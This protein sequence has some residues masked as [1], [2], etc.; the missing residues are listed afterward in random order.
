[1]REKFP[2][3]TIIKDYGS[4]LNFKRKGLK[5]IL[6]Q[7]MS[8]EIEEIVVAH[9]DRLCRF[10]FELI[11]EFFSLFNTPIMVI[12]QR[13]QNNPDTEL[14]E[15]ILAIIHV[16]SCKKMGQRSYKTKKDNEIIKSGVKTN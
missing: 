7:A 15:D 3:H 8:G 12:N 14:A 11:E 9:R 1:M 5:T 16:F 6:E 2:D 10:A 13:E 4:G